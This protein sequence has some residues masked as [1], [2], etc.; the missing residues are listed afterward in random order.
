MKHAKTKL[1]AIILTVA[2]AVTGVFPGTAAKA[3]AGTIGAKSEAGAA[4]TALQNEEEYAGYLFAYFTGD[5]RAIHFAVSADGYH[6][7]ALNG[8]KAVITQT[9][10]RKS[11]RDPYIIKGQDGDYYMMATDLYGGE[12]AGGIGQEWQLG[13]GSQH[14]HCHLAFHRFGELGQR[15]L[16]YHPRRV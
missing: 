11:A 15:D 12:S 7:T 14:R 4:P 8:N 1:I 13:V 16:D 9:V 3:A 10:G 6:Y 5:S 2:M